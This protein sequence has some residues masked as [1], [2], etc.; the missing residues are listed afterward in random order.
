MNI[1]FE[2][3]YECCSH[4]VRVLQNHNRVIIC[5]EIT[6]QPAIG[7]VCS[8]QICPLEADEKVCR[9]TE[10]GREWVSC[11]GQKYYSQDRDKYCPHCGRIILEVE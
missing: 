3:L 1:E 5:A 6:P 4:Q 2:K 7:I 11:T 8:E 9:W 10:D